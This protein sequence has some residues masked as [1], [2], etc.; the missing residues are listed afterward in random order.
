[1]TFESSQLVVE[2]CFISASSFFLLSKMTEAFVKKY[3]LGLFNQFLSFITQIKNDDE[4][5]DRVKNKVLYKIFTV[6]F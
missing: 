3:I 6:L 1:M 4:N 2:S 5:R